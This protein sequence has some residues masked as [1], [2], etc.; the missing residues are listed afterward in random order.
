MKKNSDIINSLFV[1]DVSINTPITHLR[2]YTIG[3]VLRLMRH[4]LYQYLEKPHHKPFEN[5]HINL[6]GFISGSAMSKLLALVILVFI[7]IKKTFVL[8][9][10]V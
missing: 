9:P 2:K 4:P 3:L 7:R 8:D 1:L 10:C 6:I 5:T